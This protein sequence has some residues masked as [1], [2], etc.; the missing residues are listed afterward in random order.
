ML[1]VEMIEMSQG[2]G[3]GEFKAAWD[4]VVRD[5]LAVQAAGDEESSDED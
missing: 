5:G 1:P 4:E 2:R 3:V